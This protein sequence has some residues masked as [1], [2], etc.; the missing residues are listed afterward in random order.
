[1]REEMKQTLELLEILE[2]INKNDLKEC[3]SFLLARDITNNS[4]CSENIIDNYLKLIP[5]NVLE[6][7]LLLIESILSEKCIKYFSRRK[8]EQ[9]R[10]IK[11]IIEKHLESMKN[12][13]N[14]F[15][16]FS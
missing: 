14:F 13:K 5:S 9:Y 16:R 8:I 15:I 4:F 3:S 1:M 10:K 6:N 11:F 2:S 12:C 7:V